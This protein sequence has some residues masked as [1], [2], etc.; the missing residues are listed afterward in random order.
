MGVAGSGK[1][2][3]SKEILRRFSAVYLDNNHIVDAFFPDTRNGTG[4]EKLRPLFYRALYTITEENLKMGNNVLLDVR[5]VKEMQDPKWRRSIKCLAGM[6]KAKLVVIRCHCSDS[7]LRSRLETR[8]E[9]RDRWKLTH[10]QEFLTQQPTLTRIPVPHLEIDT[11]R[12]LLVNV[13]A[14]LRYIL[15]A[16]ASA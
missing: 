8:G 1:T 9:S 16:S 12:S 11:E 10:W 3:L 5:H 7:V 2:T 4:Y 14:A 6:T 15:H 13:N